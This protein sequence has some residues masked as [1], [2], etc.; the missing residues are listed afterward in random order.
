MFVRLFLPSVSP[1]LDFCCLQLG[2]GPRH[3]SLLS[4]LFV[5][6]RQSSE[7]QVSSGQRGSSG[8]NFFWLRKRKPLQHQGNCFIKRGVIRWMQRVTLCSCLKQVT[9]SLLVG[10]WLLGVRGRRLTQTRLPACKTRNRWCR[11]MRHLSE[12]LNPP[13]SSNDPLPS[14]SSLFLLHAHCFFS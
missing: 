4:T 2:S 11:K 14:H 1:S 12:A 9:Q 3:A 6:C 13:F 7:A 10:V 8:W 5:F